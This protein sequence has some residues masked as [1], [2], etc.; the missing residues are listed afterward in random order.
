MRTIMIQ[1]IP[2]WLELSGLSAAR[3]VVAGAG[4]F[5]GRPRPR[6]DTASF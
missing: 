1:L 3:E 5:R 4:V 6:L 2:T